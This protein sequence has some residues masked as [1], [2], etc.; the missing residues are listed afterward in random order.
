MLHPSGHSTSPGSDQE[1]TDRSRVTTIFRYRIMS[2]FFPK[3]APSHDQW[4]L[5]NF[6]MKMK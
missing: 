1:V 5:Q 4:S 2:Q 3:T 6:F